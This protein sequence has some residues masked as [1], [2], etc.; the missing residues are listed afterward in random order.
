MDDTQPFTQAMPPTQESESS[1]PLMV[2]QPSS[3]QTLQPPPP[4]APVSGM[5]ATEAL[6]NSMENPTIPAQ[7]GPSQ[8]A[9][10]P[11]QNPLAA[12]LSGFSSIPS[13]AAAIPNPKPYTAPPP[14]TEPSIVLGAG[15]SEKPP[16]RR[17]IDDVEE[18]KMRPDEIRSPG[19]VREEEVSKLSIAELK[20]MGLGRVASGEF[21]ESFLASRV[22]ET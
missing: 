10:F 16:V 21:V 18:G 6:L 12:P 15:L 11:E 19:V 5:S 22:C 13:K 2:A 20:K 3:N 17:I 8:F 14:Y 9:P 4:P 7:A 1:V